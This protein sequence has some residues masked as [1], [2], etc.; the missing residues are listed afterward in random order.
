MIHIV[1][2]ENCCGCSSCTNICPS[3]AIKMCE[4]EEGFLYP[5][6]DTKVCV[7]CNLCEVVCPVL[8]QT[9]ERKPLNIYAAKNR[10][11]EVRMESSSGGIF[12]MLAEHVIQQGGIVFG[13]KFDECWKVIHNYTET[14]GG[15]AP[16]RGSKYIQSDLGR[17][18]ND[19][20]SFLENNRLVLFSGTP[21]QIRGLKLFLKKDYPNLFSVDFVCHGVPSPK[22]F[23][24]YLTENIT[25][26]GNKISSI[27][28]RDKRLGW[29]LFSFTAGG[30]KSIIHTASLQDD[31]F[32]K[33]FLHNLY[34][35]PS[36]HA[37]PSKSLKSG[38]E[39]T[40]ADYWGV[41]HV[42]PSFDDNKGVSLVMVNNTK[43]ENLFK[44]IEPIYIESNYNDALKGN[45][46]I[47]NSTKKSDNRDLFY[48]LYRKGMPFKRIINKLTKEKFY[49]RIYAK[50]KRAIRI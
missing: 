22:V 43:G 10:N 31:L 11:E 28:F 23:N 46:S 33:G 38:S 14:A 34:L 16:L 21:C 44:S 5:N 39:I 17:T 41:E 15:L 37:C 49:W 20:K 2:K 29:H 27:K 36:C 26:K 19:V 45:P 12:T 48:N 1:D 40:L 24:S 47:E 13:A 7:N 6:I 3:R 35:R 50:I 18:Y 4:D 32:L 42:F 8:N 9:K 25:R 30:T